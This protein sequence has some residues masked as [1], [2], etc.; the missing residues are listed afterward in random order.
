MH[1]D[2]YGDDSLCRKMLLAEL[3]YARLYV[4]CLALRAISWERMPAEQRDLARSPTFLCSL[5]VRR[6]MRS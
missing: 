4:S 1:L 5:P 2:V 6:R 3:H